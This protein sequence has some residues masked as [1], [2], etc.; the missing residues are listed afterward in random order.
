MEERTSKSRSRASVFRFQEEKAEGQLAEAQ[1]FAQQVRRAAQAPHEICEEIEKAEA[2]GD[3]EKA[4]EIA[5]AAPIPVHILEEL[6][7]FEKAEAQANQDEEQVAAAE[8]V[9]AQAT[10]KDTSGPAWERDAVA[11]L[12]TAVEKLQTEENRKEANRK[13]ME[14]RGKEITSVLFEEERFGKRENVVCTSCG[15]IGDGLRA[16]QKVTWNHKGEGPSA[17]DFQN[18]LVRLHESHCKLCWEKYLGAE[19]FPHLR[20]WSHRVWGPKPS[21]LETCA[22]L[23]E[24]VRFMQKQDDD[25]RARGGYGS[26]ERKPVGVAPVWHRW[27]KKK[28]HQHMGGNWNHWRKSDDWWKSQK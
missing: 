25:S 6:Q 16:W 24:N 3:H 8:K 28:K 1:D 14:E 26:G 5:K 21:L 23:G 22:Q 13:W 19:S 17:T 18:N 15:T 20:V 27:D 10:W 7:R 4:K 12:Q 2:A 9:E 11:D